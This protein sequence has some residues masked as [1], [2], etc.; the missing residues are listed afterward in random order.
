MLN[1][2][3]AFA[4]MSDV[5]NPHPLMGMT[6]H[7]SGKVSDLNNITDSIKSNTPAR[8]TTHVAFISSSVCWTPGNKLYTSFEVGSWGTTSCTS[9]SAVADFITENN[10]RQCVVGPKAYYTSHASPKLSYMF[11]VAPKLNL[12]TSHTLLEYGV[13]QNYV[14]TKAAIINVT[15]GNQLF[16]DSSRK[17]F[18]QIGL[19]YLIP[20][21][22][23]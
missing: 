17:T 6:K 14:I 13:I 5:E 2:C 23:L 8:A 1:M 3:H 16:E 20:K 18:F 11:Y 9:F 15:L 7:S 22:K 10:K 4:Q 19:V 21:N 12:A